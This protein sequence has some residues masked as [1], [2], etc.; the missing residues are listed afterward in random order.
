MTTPDRIYVEE[1]ADA[2]AET[3]V[4]GAAILD[5]MVEE[6]CIRQRVLAP[7]AG[8]QSTPRC[9]EGRGPATA[10]APQGA[11]YLTGNDHMSQ[12]S[13]NAN[14]TRPKLSPVVKRSAPYET[15]EIV[16]RE[17]YPREERLIHYRD[18]FYQW[19]GSHY[20]EAD[21]GEIRARLYAFFERRDSP[22][23]GGRA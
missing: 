6:R 23:A 8:T 12:S 5:Q 22:D 14:L 4:D 18:N 1:A 11:A 2:S 7:T 9:M 15:A 16:L 21:T 10:A 3:I 13:P 19:T 17:I 20:R